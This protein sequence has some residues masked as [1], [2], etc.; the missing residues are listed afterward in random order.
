MAVGNGKKRVTFTVEVP[1][2][3]EV[4]L[5]GSFNGWEPGRTPMKSDG[6]G[7]WKAIV[8]LEPGTYEYRVVAD[9]AWL[10]DPRA[11]AVAN[12]FGSTNSVREV[13]AA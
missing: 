1:Q 5:C 12:Q 6:K 7:A 2:A 9:G 4:Y 13:A 3:S 8:M 10:S 11:P